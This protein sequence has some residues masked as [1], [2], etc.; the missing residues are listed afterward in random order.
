[1]NV[2]VFKPLGKYVP[3]DDKPTSLPLSPI[4]GE[5]LVGLRGHPVSE[6]LLDPLTFYPSN[7]TSR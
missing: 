7:I 6:V 4:H 1:M 5:T 3:M 2:S